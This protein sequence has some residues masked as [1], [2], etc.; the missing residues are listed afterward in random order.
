MPT[1]LNCCQARLL[2]SY[3]GQLAI[4]VIGLQTIGTVTVNQALADQLDSEI[5][6]QLSTSGLNTHLATTTVL[7]RVGIRDLRIDGGV[8][9]QGQS[10]AVPGTA[11]GDPLPRQTALVI[12][13]YT[14]TATRSGRGR[15]YFGGFSELE[16]G[17]NGEASAALVTALAA[18]WSAMGSVFNSHALT[19][20]VI[21]RDSPET[22]ITVTRNP[23]AP[24]EETTT[25]HYAARTGIVRG[26]LR[27]TVRDD[28]W[29][30]QRRRNNG[31]G[32]AGLTA[33]RNARFF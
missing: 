21:S 12:T 13:H 24:D 16:N 26:I 23:G 33:L 25:R 11:A 5:K 3:D 29:D 4:N 6:T 27:N 7:E 15:T 31:R 10:A 8:E 19:P 20:G 30:T 14:D 2:W 17:T 1:I 18:F 32:A 28:Q 22:I 9:F